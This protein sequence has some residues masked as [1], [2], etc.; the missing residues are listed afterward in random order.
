[1]P[2]FDAPEWL[3]NASDHTK[4]MYE[5][6]CSKFNRDA[7]PRRADIDPLELP[8]SFLPCITIVEVVQDER[9]YV[10]RLVGTREVDVRG[11]DPTGRSVVDGYFGSSSPEEAL[12]FYDSVVTSRSPVYNPHPYLSADGRYINEENL[13][14][15]LSDDG[16]AVNR[17]LVFSTSVRHPKV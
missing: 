1:M 3:T 4:T 8:R 7:L 5:F 13:Y 17:I 11:R 14:L 16:K 9:R 12:R 15:P 10:Y 6:W 2:P